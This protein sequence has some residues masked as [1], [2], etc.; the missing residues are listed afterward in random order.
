[1]LAGISAEYQSRRERGDAAGASSRLGR[2]LYAPMFND[3]VRP[4]DTLRKAA[5]PL[6][7]PNLDLAF[8]FTQLLAGQ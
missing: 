7:I 6:Q 2:P 3:P 5:T 4:A 8:G 1:M